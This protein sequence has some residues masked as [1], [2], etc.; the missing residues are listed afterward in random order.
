M[1][2]VFGEDISFKN[3]QNYDESFAN[4]A[5]AGVADVFQ[6]ADFSMVNLE[7]IFGDPEKH[8]P[9]PKIGP[10]LISPANSMGISML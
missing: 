4:K 8:T 6:K 2:V 1:K 3:V 10:N 7:N 5:M 9:I